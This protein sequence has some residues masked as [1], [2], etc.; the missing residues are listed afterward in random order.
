MICWKTEKAIT[1][2]PL[3]EVSVKPHQLPNNSHWNVQSQKVSQLQMK[4]SKHDEQEGF[5]EVIKN[6]VGK[7]MERKWG[8]DLL[9]FSHGASN[10]SGSHSVP[11]TKW[12]GISRLLIWDSSHYQRMGFRIRELQRWVRWTKPQGFSCSIE[13]QHAINFI[14]CLQ[15]RSTL[16]QSQ[17]S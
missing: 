4:L 6:N 17:E 8:D 16:S 1:S 11:E 14:I 3:S 10:L 2:L 5:R 9:L 7:E 15:M 13:M 12:D